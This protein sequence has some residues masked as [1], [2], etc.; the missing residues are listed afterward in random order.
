MRVDEGSSKTF[1]GFWQEKTAASAAKT[2]KYLV[3]IDIMF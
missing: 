1:S 2:N 3:F